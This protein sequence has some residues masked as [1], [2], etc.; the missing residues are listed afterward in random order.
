MGTPQ[1]AVPSLEALI[2]SKHTV[3]CA[4]CQPDKPR[5]R[6]KKLSPP[7]VKVTASEHSVRVIQP[8]NIRSEEFGELI[9]DISPDIICVV[10][11]GKIIPPNILKIPPLGCVNVHAS[12]LPS[13]RGAAPVNWA[14]IN[15][16]EVT[17]V[18][19]MLMDEG[20]DTGDILLQTKTLVGEDE[21]SA[22]LSDRLSRLGASLLIETIDKL[23]K[24]A[25]KPT[26]Q[27]ETKATYA[28]LLRKEHGLINWSEESRKIRN[29]VRGTQPWPGAYTKLDGKLL[30]I[31]N[32]VISE[33]ARGKPGEVLK[34]HEGTFRVATG[35]GAVDIM[36]LQLEGSKRMS[37]EDFLRGRTIKAGKIL[38]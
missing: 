18:T 19:T 5:G 11:Y 36:E 31:F 32:T 25:V 30:K 12:L 22:E 21:T 34:S 35:D 1:F 7:P 20:M 13:Y 17:G 2:D 26:K 27:D 9:T 6:G 29:L 24:N 10:A 38:G 15:G 37:A 23:E 8:E 28:P 14:I 3:K 33:G 16:E 4:I